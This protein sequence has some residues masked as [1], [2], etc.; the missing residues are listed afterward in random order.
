MKVERSEEEESSTGDADTGQA[1]IKSAV[2]RA[3]ACLITTATFGAAGLV[4]RIR[5]RT[6]A[7]NDIG[8]GVRADVDVL[9][10]DKS[11]I[12]DITVGA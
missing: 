4:V 6:P 3:R 7:A 10:V 11:T 5:A 2:K 12:A 8:E 9:A 1:E